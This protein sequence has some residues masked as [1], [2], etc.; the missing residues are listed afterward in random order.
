MTVRN[1][2]EGLTVGLG[3]LGE[4]AELHERVAAKVV[5][6]AARLTGTLDARERGHRASPVTALVSGLR[7]FKGLSVQDDLPSTGRRARCES[8][9]SRL[10]REA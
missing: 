2:C 4:H 10:R 3:G 7:K 6:L 1:V 5:G 8:T 9:Q